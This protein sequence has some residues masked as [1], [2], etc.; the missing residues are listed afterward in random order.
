MPRQ[1][2]APGA[3][4]GKAPAPQSG[5]SAA[6]QPAAPEGGTGPAGAGGWGFVRGKRDGQSDRRG[7]R[8]S[9]SKQGDEERAIQTTKREQPACGRCSCGRALKGWGGSAG[10]SARPACGRLPSWQHA[11][12]AAPSP[13]GCR[14]CCRA[15]YCLP[16]P[17][18]QLLLRFPLHVAQAAAGPIKV[19]CR[20]GAQG[21][22]C[23]TD[24]CM[25]LRKCHPAI[26]PPI[27]PLPQPSS[28]PPT[29]ASSSSHSRRQRSYSGASIS[30][31]I[32]R[33]LSVR[34]RGEGAKR[35]ARVEGILQNS[36]GQ[37]TWPLACTPWSLGSRGL[38]M[39]QL[40]RGCPR[41]E[42]CS[43]SGTAGAP[44]CG[45]R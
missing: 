20:Q 23:P 45:K 12:A 26:L 16:L 40:G 30:W 36:I 10:W 19:G 31:N 18:Q 41:P 33:T 21:I 7:L 25:A 4:A 15:L 11:V 29:C 8:G 35:L 38:G 5:R 32:L 2:F 1:Q 3:A 27:R 24:T 37:T 39:G 14:R 34:L 43:A 9:T 42:H 6:G 44:M 22:L 17:P 13:C 28:P